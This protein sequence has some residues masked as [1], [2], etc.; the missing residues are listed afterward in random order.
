MRLR[1]ADLFCRERPGQRER[2]QHRHQHPKDFQTKLQINRRASRCDVRYFRPECADRLFCRG[3][4]L[5]VEVQL[6]ALQSYQISGVPGPE[7]CRRRRARGFGCHRSPSA[8][9]F[10]LFA[11]NGRLA[12]GS[13][14]LV[15]KA[16]W[17]LVVRSLFHSLSICIFWRR[18]AAVRPVRGSYGCG[19]P[20]EPC[21]WACWGGKTAKS[22]GH[23]ICAR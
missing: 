17:D 6:L 1:R 21:F 15:R 7:C 11:V 22:S 14:Q 13:K 9:Y 12:C 2:R 19:V 20:G 23:G 8:L 4:S 5:R 18:Q 10:Q 16:A 3:F